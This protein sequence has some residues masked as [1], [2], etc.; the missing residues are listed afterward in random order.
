[1]KFARTSGGRK[2][3]AGFASVDRVGKRSQRTAGGQLEH[4]K[5]TTPG[6]RVQAGARSETLAGV[7]FP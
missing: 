7:S 6:H 5:R 4:K 1:M 2:E 3:G